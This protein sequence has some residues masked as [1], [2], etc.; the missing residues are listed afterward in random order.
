MLVWIYVSNQLDGRDEAPEQ[1]TKVFSLFVPKFMF[2]YY[3]EI[4][5]DKRSHTLTHNKN[6][7]FPPTPPPLFPKVEWVDPLRN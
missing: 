3:I 7:P 2:G 6:P 5:M 4:L 1:R